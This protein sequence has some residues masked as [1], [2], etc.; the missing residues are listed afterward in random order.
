LEPEGSG[1]ILVIRLE[2]G[3]PI[4]LVDLLL[5]LTRGCQIP[6]GSVVLLASLSHL[7]DVGLAAYAADLNFAATK[8][9]RALRG[10]V[11][12]LPGLVFPAAKIVEPM[13][14]RGLADLLAWSAEAALV[15]DG[16]TPVLR[17]CYREL[18]DLLVSSGDGD[19]Q[20]NYGV[21]LRLP[22][23]LGH[24][25]CKKWE[26]SGPENLKNSTGPLSAKDILKVINMATSE[27]AVGL[28]LNYVKVAN[29]NGG[30]SMSL[31]IDRDV[32]VIGASHAKR[33]H[34]Y[35]KSTGVKSRWLETRNWRPKTAAVDLLMAEMEKGVEGLNNPAIIFMLLDN[36]YFQT[37]SEDGSII[38]H[39]RDSLGHYHV[40]GDL[41][42]GPAECAKKLFQQVIPAFKKFSSLDKIL[43]TPIPRYLW[44]SCCG[45]KDHAPNIRSADYP[46]DQLKCLDACHRLWRTMAHR[47]S[48]P[49]FKVCNAGRQLADRI[50]W[51]TDPVHP[52]ADGY[53]R[54][55]RYISQGLVDMTTKRR[56]LLGDEEGLEDDLP[57]P[58]QK[59]VKED[60][61]TEAMPPPR[62]RPAWTSSSG[63]FVSPPVNRPFNRGRG[64]PPGRRN[65]GGRRFYY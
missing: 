19:A 11:I 61:D 31:D 25:D 4:E 22:K 52:T 36:G 30:P 20:T 21:R 16:A 51:A 58:R 32:V 49:N 59:R 41:V 44:D 26:T 40:D 38:P 50:V 28:G 10:G 64:W 24:Q 29:L 18:G 34:E 14:V 27:L 37:A 47:E 54:I 5:D 17:L 62:F 60:E 2:F 55:A 39:S 13:I 65:G 23:Q 6:A 33:L 8:L 9:T 7:A 46:E 42:C 63:H 43:M 35:L 12:V 48:I 53:E 1:C 3:S 15:P 56:L 45:D 57:A